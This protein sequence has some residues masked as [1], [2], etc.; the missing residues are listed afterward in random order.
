MPVPVAS[1]KYLSEFILKMCFLSFMYYF[2]KNLVFMRGF[3][4]I[5]FTIFILSFL[6]CRSDFD[7]VASDGKLE[8]SSSKIFL[9]TVFNNIASSTYGLKVYNR[10]SND[11]KIPIIQFGKGA[12]TKYRMMV[13]G[14]TGVDVD[15]NGFGDGKEFRD[16]ELL[17]KDSLFVFIEITNNNLGV[18]PTE[19]TFDDQILFDLGSRQQK[20]DVTTLI[21]DA[22]FIFPN[23]SLPT[24]VKELLTINTTNTDIVGHRLTANDF[25]PVG[26]WHITNLK[27]T[28]VYGYM[29]VPDG[30]TL[31]IDQ[32]ASLYFHADGSS[33]LIVENGGR[34]VVNGGKNVYD[35]AGLLVTR[36]E[37]TMEADRLEPFFE[38]VPGQWGGVF[39]ISNKMIAASNFIK[40]LKLKNSTFGFYTQNIDGVGVMPN[41]DIQN[42][43]IYNSSAFGFLNRNTKVVG[44][45]VVVNYCGQ[46]NLACI[47]GN[48]DFVHC[49]FNNN[50]YSSKQRS[51]VLYDYYKDNL[52]VVQ[53]LA[54]S[55][56]F[57]NCIIFGSANAVELELDYLFA[58][59]VST[60]VFDHCLIKFNDAGTKYAT[61]P[62]YNSIRSGNSANVSANISNVTEAKF[63]NA[64]KNQLNILGTSPAV[65]AAGFSNSGFNDILDLPRTSPSDIG[66]YNKP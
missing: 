5:C 59:T 18:V 52:N 38:D 1:I 63:K 27:P 57:K 61:L 6:S 4:F 8:F 60:T 64:T 62:I 10:S 23:R 20:I 15:G 54:I 43:Q 29:L 13:D 16:V 40:H 34:L 30:E 65:G 50:W 66:A 11:I 35:S 26:S 41:L 2:Y 3:I 14:M 19:F 45:N 28:V 39:I 9:D 24:N 47:G 31:T 46:A 7:T 17:A 25:S 49:T 56:A 58:P 33:G 51:V 37:V 32:G 44:K 53:S 22:K 42:S 12:T 21:W 36:N 48:Y 55:A